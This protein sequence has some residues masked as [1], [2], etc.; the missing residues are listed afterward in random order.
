MGWDRT[1]PTDPKYRSKD[2][3]DR[4]AALV[5]Q[6]QRDGYLECTADVCVFPSREI[7]EANGKRRD[8]LHLGH[9]PDGITYRGAQHAACNLY[10]MLARTSLSGEPATELRR[11]PA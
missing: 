6:L 5:R 7:T 11:W 10:E 2:H 4:R 1:A 3:R 8:G 9:E